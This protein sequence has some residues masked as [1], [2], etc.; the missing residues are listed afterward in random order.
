MGCD[1]FIKLEAQADQFRVWA[2]TAY[3]G[4]RFGEW[5]CDYQNWGE[6]YSAFSLFLRE[7]PFSDWSEEAIETVLYLVAR[8]NESGILT[9]EIAEEPH[10]LLFIAQ[11][12]AN[13]AERDAKVSLVMEFTN[14]PVNLQKTEPILL[15]WAE[16]ADEYVRRSALGELGRQKSPAVERLVEQA[17]N[18]L[19]P[20]Q[21]Y[22]RMTALY[23]L[24]NSGSP[25]LE[26]YLREAEAGGRPFLAAYAAKIRD[27]K[28]D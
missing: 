10:R 25:L 17:W 24:Y 5:E 13:S 4:Q 28:P 15:Q 8:D 7:C 26:T 1:A 6:I 16:D 2:Q 12:G 14:L 18:R 27:Q 20:M 23:A 21:E 11:K 9:S 19:D 22:Q 3:P